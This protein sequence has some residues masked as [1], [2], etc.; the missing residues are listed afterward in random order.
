MVIVVCIPL[1]K[2]KIGMN[3]WYGIRIRKAFQSEENWY[4][5]NRYG[6][7]RMILWSTVPIVIGIVTLFFPV[8]DLVSFLLVIF[9]PVIF[10]CIMP[11]IEILRFA[12]KL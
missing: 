8:G 12:K 11:L 2:G 5:I 1:L 3:Y 4:T 9:V 10:I 7:Q 6:A